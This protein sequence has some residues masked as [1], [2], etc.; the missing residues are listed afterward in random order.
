MIVL[1]G[2]SVI[3]LKPR[4]VAGTSFEIALS[5]YAGEDCIITP[6]SHNDECTR[7][8]RQFRGP[9]NYQYRTLEILK[10]P[11]HRQIEFILSPRRPLKFYNH[12]TAGEAKQH[13]D[14]RVWET[15]TKISIIRN[16]FDYTVSRY[17]MANPHSLRRPVFDEWCMD[18]SNIFLENN[19]QY[20]INNQDI[21]DFYI[22]YD[23]AN[24]DILDFERSYSRLKGLSA[25]FA[26]L[27][28]K[29]HYRPKECTTSHMFENAPRAK[30]HISSVYGE[31][32]EKFGFAG[33]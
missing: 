6:I 23:K 30:A 2:P 22:R 29:S 20:Y 18:N 28:A 4:K 16:P 15:Y 21:I 19:Q 33:P 17:F 14:K 9:Q 26:S 1:H 31:E 8:E 10:L 32:I 7:A 24:S 27:S 13:L 12:M 3:F 11:I 25:V 5:K